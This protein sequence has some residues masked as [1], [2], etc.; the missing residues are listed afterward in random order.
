MS[1]HT[2]TRLHGLLAIGLA[3]GCSMT[4]RP[5]GAAAQES[6]RETAVTAIRNVRVFD[7]RRLLG[8]ATVVIRDGLIADVG[9]DVG[10]PAGARVVEGDGRTLLPGLIDAHTHTIAPAAL[11]TALAFGVTTQFDM[12]T[13][14][15]L[16]A[17][18]RAEQAAGRASSRA[19]LLSAGSVA[20]VP[21]GH[22]TQY[23]IP[24]P[25][26]SSPDSADAFVRARVGEGSDYIKIIVDDF[27]AYGRK[28][29]TL[30]EATMRALVGAAH[31]HGKLAVVH[32][33]TL[34]TAR[35][36][37]AAGADGFVHVWV[38]SIP[39]DA[40]VA[41]MVRRR[42]FVVPTLTV[43]A[44]VAGVAS[45]APLVE[46]ERLAPMLGPEERAQLRAHFPAP[47][48]GSS[49]ATVKAVF[50]KL[51]RGSVRI[52]AGTDAP[53]PG[54]SYG[55]SMHRE[56]EL[57]VEAGLS[58]TAALAAATSAPAETFG[59]RDR[60][61]I[62]RGRRADLVLVDG[63]PTTDIRATRAIVHVWKGGVPYDRVAYRARVAA[64]LESAASPG[65]PAVP[66]GAPISNFDAGTTATSF[67]TG[68]VQTTDAMM[69]G[70]S[71][72]RIQ[73]VPGGAAGTSHALEVTGEIDG[74]LPFAWGGAMFFPS[75][76]PMTPT[77]LSASKGIRFSARGDG[78][79]YRV[80]LFWRGGG[81]VPSA[82][83]FTAG[84]AWQEFSF[85][86][87]DFRGSDGSDVM[88]IAIVG[89]PA[90]GPYKFLIDS[91]RLY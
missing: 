78:K 55:V 23:G 47:P 17:Q 10:V 1:E 38:D 26:I 74:S 54:T 14:P 83:T 11:E 73:A 29:P 3:L 49:F 40:F 6:A 85:A 89:G 16:A 28:I 43:R 25:T 24:I 56:L 41:E 62:E 61:L 34:G 13:V 21:R 22:G 27:S 48:S 20:T 91:V 35:Q 88:A 58:G 46:D 32:V 86:W 77:N 31:R 39:D 52:L 30:D 19:D 66:A 7:G 9:R 4:A 84:P 36:A 8:A 50:A 82:R 71:T 80:L 75:T 33:T 72:A 67:G 79:P 68:W 65:M 90:A 76:P 18:L 53:N 63:D 45:G 60:G 12:F 57:L 59:L 37:V 81:Q 15:T 42:T 69:G 44:S 64:R 70:K 51:A 5:Q 87:S 2:V